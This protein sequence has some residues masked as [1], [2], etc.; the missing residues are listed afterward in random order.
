M[1]LLGS[2]IIILGAT[3]QTASVNI[4]MLIAGRIIGGIGNG[5]YSIESL[6]EYGR[7]IG[8]QKG[9]NTSVSPVYHAETSRPGSRGRALIGEL[10]VL[11]VGWLVAQFVTFGFSFAKSGIQWVRKTNCF[12]NTY[13][14]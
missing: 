11:D 9:L 5:M 7:L 6:V 4:G 3:I 13:L 1:Q 12:C 8:V 2:S 14:V 10:F